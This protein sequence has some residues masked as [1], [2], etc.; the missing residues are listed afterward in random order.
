MKRK[1]S[2]DAD[3]WTP[4]LASNK[5]F[6]KRAQDSRKRSR[7]ELTHPNLQPSVEGIVTTR[8][9][10]SYGQK[11]NF[12][13][14]FDT[15]KDAYVWMTVAQLLDKFHE[16]NPA[17]PVDTV[18]RFLRARD[19]IVDK[20][21]HTSPAQIRRSKVT[22]ERLIQYKTGRFHVI[23]QD[24]YNEISERHTMGLMVSPE[25]FMASMK[26]K[27]EHLTDAH[28]CTR[29]WL[30]R[31]M[32]RFELSLR[33]AS[34]VHGKTVLERQE[35]L[36][37]FYKYVKV[38]CTPQPHSGP[39]TKF[40]RFPLEKRIH[41]DQVPLE[42]QGTLN[43]SVAP[44]S[45]K[46]V[47]IKQSKVNLDFRVATLMLYFVAK[48]ERPWLRPAICFRLIPLVEN[49]NVDHCTPKSSKLRK[50]FEGL[51]QA[52]PEIDIYVQKKGYFDNSVC[53][54]AA[55]DLVDSFQ[56]PGEYLV[57]LENLKGHTNIEYLDI[58]KRE[59]NAFVLFTPTNC[60]D[61]VAVTDAGLGRSIKNLM[62][63][64]FKE[65][66]HTHLS[67]WVDGV[68]D[69]AC[70][71]RLYCEWLVGAMT[72]FYSNKGQDRVLRAFEKCGLASAYDGSEDNLISVDGVDVSRFDLS[73]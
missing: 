25:W 64:R 16:F 62:R 45:A 67:D 38:L 51:R 71:R 30:M 50:E 8:A 26:Q 4:V 27:V 11:L 3:V 73:L 56:Q 40:G 39:T 13:L 57:C 52:F 33:K 24:L 53:L 10:Y 60:T 42:F 65:H 2:E 72:E 70:R 47:Q 59:G 18:R 61:V 23:E 63:R 7:Q 68:I 29:G 1:R 14:I 20:A 43:K 35:L 69:P 19:H 32:N 34:N 6:K 17:V 54:Q 48:A 37:N 15:I 21:H 28:N 41:G 12:L 44:K 66:F 9:H 49:G 22:P 36:E 58:L 46:R 5:L 55:N 31:F